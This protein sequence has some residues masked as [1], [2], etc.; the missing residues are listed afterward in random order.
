M[1]PPA[2]AADLEGDGGERR[3]ASKRAAGGPA[4]QPDSKRRKK[5]KKEKKQQ[6]QQQ[7]LQQQLAAGTAAAAA[8]GSAPSTSGAGKRRWLG[9]DPANRQLDVPSK[10]SN[11]RYVESS[12]IDYLALNCSGECTW[13]GRQG[14]GLGYVR[15]LQLPPPA[16][17]PDATQPPRHPPVSPA[18]P[19]A[20]PQRPSL[21]R[22]APRFPRPWPPASLAW[23][24]T[25][26]ATCRLVG[27]PFY[28]CLLAPEWAC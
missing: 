27:L 15:G 24:G 17:P 22:A 11:W 23:T 18:H 9:F 12:S 10:N 6:Q 8:A 1:A 16:S 25:A 13:A 5:E 14:R 2:G 28:T 3:Q 21:R 4:G 20:R 26:W 7:Q 19:P